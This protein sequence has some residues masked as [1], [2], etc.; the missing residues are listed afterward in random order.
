MIDAEIRFDPR[1]FAATLQMRA[2]RL[3]RAFVRILLFIEAEGDRAANRAPVIEDVRD[4]SDAGFG[5]LLDDAQR[6]IVILTALE[7]APQAA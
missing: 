2:Q 6:E 7:A 3:P 5:N 4:V 1:L